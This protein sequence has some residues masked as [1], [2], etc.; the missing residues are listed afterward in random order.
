MSK[1]GKRKKNKSNTRW[2]TLASLVVCA[3]LIGIGLYFF[4]H[5]TSRSAV[6]YWFKHTLI[7]PITAIVATTPQNRSID[8]AAFQT[9][10]THIA[11]NN[12][13]AIEAFLNE[14]ANS[15]LAM[16][17]RNR[18]LLL[19]AQ[20][21]QWQVF[22]NDYQP[23]NNQ[24]VECYYLKALS[25]SGKQ[26]L[27]LAG[28]KRLWL[29]G[30]KPSD[31]CNDIFTQWQNSSDFNETYLWPRIALAIHQQ[32]WAQVTQLAHILSPEKQAW[33]ATWS[34]L[35]KDPALL[36]TKKLP[37][38]SVGQMIVIDTL[39]QWAAT[40]VDD[41]IH[42]WQTIQKQYTFTLPDTQDFYLTASLHLALNADPQAETWFAKILPQYS[43]P[44]SRAW[45]VRFSLIHQHWPDVLMRINAMPNVEQNN[46][47]WQ[48]WKAR[49]LIATGSPAAAN[50]IY[51]QLRT[52]RQYYGFLAA[53]QQK[54][55][56][57]IQQQHYPQDNTL[58]TPYTQQM[59]QIQQL[60]KKNQ[61]PQALQLTQ[62]LL[63]QLND[64]GKYT[65]ANLF[66]QWGWYAEAMN[67]VNKL[68]FQDDLSLRFPMPHHVLITQLS[69]AANIEPALIYAIARQESSFHEDVFSSAGGLGILQ[70]TLVTAQQFDPNITQAALYQPD[71]NINI[72]I[73]YL[74][75][76]T[77]QFDGHPLLIASAYNAGPQK[78]RRWQPTI[79][80][81]PADIWIETRPW[82]ETRN[83]LKNILSYDAVYQYLLGQT[84]NIAAFM[85]NVPNINILT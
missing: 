12:K 70:L 43:T 45:Q 28:A 24:A 46:N 76:L 78:T 19:L 48:Y 74:K 65:L 47:V 39:K 37:N 15:P 32:D 36:P 57:T 58:L 66:S 2:Y 33:V 79:E 80:P 35:Q 49:A 25:A 9:L 55:A 10:S 73:L 50:N 5:P 82:E 56:L 85:Q 1:G 83:Y 23:T 69:S 75:K 22:M 18:W 54:S 6:H 20:N 77:R 61:L 62:D 7:A 14:N 4:T 38:N 11:L 30:Y 17:L 13:T 68:P 59:T 26:T 40:H 44:Q 51:A 71:I 53:Y 3:I 34:S 72:S 84:P 81:M 41:A 64:L 52:Q 31:A 67:I 27:A 21:H 8:Y 63:N 29:A 42:Y 60:Y 16:N